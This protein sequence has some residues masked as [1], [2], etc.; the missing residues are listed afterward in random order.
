MKVNIIVAG[1]NK[2]SFV[3]YQVKLLEQFLEE[4]FEYY[5]YDKIFT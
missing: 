3:P 2:P 4:D 5:L 1:F